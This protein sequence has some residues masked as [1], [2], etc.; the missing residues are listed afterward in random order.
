MLND[1]SIAVKVEYAR[2]LLM[3]CHHCVRDARAALQ[4]VGIFLELVVGRNYCFVGVCKASSLHPQLP[5]ALA[6]A[7]AS[8]F[9]MNHYSIST[10][11]HPNSQVSHCAPA[12][13]FI[14]CSPP[15][16]RLL[17]NIVRLNTFLVSQ[18][19]LA[20]ASFFLMPFFNIPHHPS[21]TPISHHSTVSHCRRAWL[22]RDSL[23]SLP[24]VDALL[25][26][27]KCQFLTRMT[28]A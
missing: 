9:L 19:T 17:P 22:I 2:C 1:I 25:L 14:G 3:R 11:A 15:T 24:I 5:Q 20:F 21:T 7:Q 10:S 8:L 26:T 16:C 18:P 12:C 13:N 23:L 6:Y 27:L 28:T 4:V